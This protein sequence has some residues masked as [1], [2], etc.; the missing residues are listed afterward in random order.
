MDHHCSHQGQLLA[1]NRFI[2]QANHGRF[3]PPQPAI[4]SRRIPT[5]GITPDAPIPNEFWQTVWNNASVLPT[6]VGGGRSPNQLVYEAFGT[7]E[8]QTPFTMLQGAINKVKGQLEGYYQPITVGDRDTYLQD[9]QRGDPTARQR[10][11]RPLRE[12]S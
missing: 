3:Y 1:V 10:L 9:L 8:N 7:V 12:V 4:R 5:A 11:L 2:M 6:D